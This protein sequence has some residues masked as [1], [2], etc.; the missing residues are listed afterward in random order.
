MTKPQKCEYFFN[1]Y[2]SSSARIGM[3]YMIY[4]IQRGFSKFD[5]KTGK[6]APIYLDPNKNS[7]SKVGKLPS[8]KL[9]T[10]KPPNVLLRVINAGV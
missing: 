10:I 6:T 1:F 2:L 9:K 5:S 3:I 8:I 4:M 7:T